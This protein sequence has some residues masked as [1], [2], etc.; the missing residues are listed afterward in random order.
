MRLR[1]RIP[2]AF[3]LLAA[4]LVTDQFA[5][6]GASAAAPPANLISNGPYP[7]DDSASKSATPALSV[8]APARPGRP[9]PK[10]DFEIWDGD[11]T[12]ALATGTGTRTTTGRVVWTVPAGKLVDTA[13]YAWRTRV[14]DGGAVG[15]WSEFHPIGVD[16]VDGADI[17]AEPPTPGAVEGLT[18]A[19]AVGGAYLTWQA[20]DP[21]PAASVGNY[22]LEALPANGSGPAIA[23]VVVPG[24]QNYAAFTSLADGD[25]VYTVTALNDWHAG[26][27]VQSAPARPASAPQQ[28]EL[29]TQ[30]AGEYLTAQGRLLTGAA[31]T[32]QD[33]AEA[34]AYGEA[35]RDVVLA[36]GPTA[37]DQREDQSRAKLRYTGYD[38]GLSDVA[39]VPSADGRAVTVYATVTEHLTQQAT[40]K[41]GQ[42]EQVTEEDGNRFTFTFA[43]PAAARTASAAPPV[44]TA[45]TTED[46]APDSGL[47]PAGITTKDDD[48]GPPPEPL[49]MDENGFVEGPPLLQT[50]VS[51]DAIAW[52]AW[53]YA[54]NRNKSYKVKSGTDCTNFVSQAMRHGGLKMRRGWYRSDSYWWYNG[55]WPNYGSFTWYAAHNNWNHMWKKRRAVFRRYFNQAVKGD[56]LY[57]DLNGNGSIDH[58]AI[59]NGVKD[60]HIWYAQHT[61]N[62][63]NV[64][65]NAKWRQYPK[66]RVY[67]AHVTG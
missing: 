4:L 29:Y 46:A 5:A 59:I 67:I 66:M 20:A 30:V 56:I 65:L 28:P 45:A 16:T 37:V 12:A 14:T 17:P 64:H 55:V 21:G 15:A 2:A 3:C 33:A 41:D 42:T 38:S 7:S 35:I 47:P 19:P 54:Y 6:T 39:V 60:N 53:K 11:R 48:D 22:V 43:T 26:P 49:A 58:A 63:Y 57:F 31:T 27:L 52:Y 61:K 51:S 25:Y 10:V 18:V 1:M 44:L 23:Q 40:Y 32:P 8:H 9:V 34:G 13:E 36:N 62:A 50:K 24:T